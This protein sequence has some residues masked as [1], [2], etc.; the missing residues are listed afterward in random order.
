MEL[1]HQFTVPVAGRGDLGA[2][3]RHRVGGASAS[4]APRSPRSRATRSTGSCKVKLGPIALRLQRLR[5]RSWRRTR[6]RT[7]SSSTPRARTSAA[8]ARPGATVTAHDGRR[9]A[10][11]PT[12]RCVTDLAITG[13]PAQFGRGV[14][15]DVSDKLLGPVRRLPRA[16]VRGGRRVGRRPRSRGRRPRGG[17]RTRSTPPPARRHPPTSCSGA[18]RGAARRPG[19]RRSPCR[20]AARPPPRVAQDDAPD[21]GNTVLPTW[22]SPTGSR[23]W[24]RWCTRRDHRSWLIARQLGPGRGRC[25]AARVGRELI[26]RGSGWRRRSSRP[27]RRRGR[28]DVAARGREDAGTGWAH[29]AQQADNPG[30]DRATAQKVGG[31]DGSASG[32]STNARAPEQNQ[33][34]PRTPGRGRVGGGLDPSATRYARMTSGV[35]SKRRPSRAG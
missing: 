27:G 21:L 16:A 24:P 31:A 4:R 9:P 35:R 22:S 7:A 33:G 13:K 20:Q 2:L 10:A 34:A 3:Q 15:Q 14:M 17:G 1:T 29:R 19:R 11:R 26:D 6:R 8:T 5:A 25:T 32:W 28:R 23:S 30:R 18:R 12:S